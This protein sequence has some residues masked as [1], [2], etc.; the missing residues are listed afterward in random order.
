M[1]S[2]AL[3][4]LFASLGANVFL[5]W[6]AASQRHRFRAL[7]REMFEGDR[8]AHHADDADGRDDLPHW[9]AVDEDSED[10]SATRAGRADIAR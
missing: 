10:P 9:E 6:V 4:G 1:P 3:V 8:A 5:L 7:V 2:G